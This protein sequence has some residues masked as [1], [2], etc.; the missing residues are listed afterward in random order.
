MP[1]VKYANSEVFERHCEQLVQEG[2]DEAA[3]RVIECV[4]KSMTA[5]WKN[6]R[7]AHQNFGEGLEMC[8]DC[9]HLAQTQVVRLVAYRDAL[10]AL[11]CKLEI[12][13]DH[14]EYLRIHEVVI[15]QDGGV[16]ECVRSWPRDEWL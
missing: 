6:E 7:I 15:T 2:I 14:V 10:E 13:F 12:T 3:R 9:S 16:L 4:A 5:Y 1:P 8:R 11:G